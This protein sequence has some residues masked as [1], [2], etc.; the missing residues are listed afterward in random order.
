[1]VYLGNSLLLVLRQALP[2]PKGAALVRANGQVKRVLGPIGI[3]QV[4]PCLEEV[5]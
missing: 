1:M 3:P 4:H 2:S 5:E